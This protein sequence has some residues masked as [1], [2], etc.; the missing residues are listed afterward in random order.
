MKLILNRSSLLLKSY[1]LKNYL[2]DFD[3]TGYLYP[4]ADRSYNIT[5][6]QPNV[7]KISLKS[8]TDGFNGTIEFTFSGTREFD[9]TGKKFYIRISGVPS[10]SCIVIPTLDSD[11]GFVQRYKSIVFDTDGLYSYTPTSSEVKLQLRALRIG[12]DNVNTQYPF[13]GQ[14]EI[15]AELY[16]VD[17]DVIVE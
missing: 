17:S 7:V 3:L 5:K 2:Y 14:K 13:T 15:I 1:E 10:K 4:T 9:I 12:I 11:G 6:V 8:T 16:I